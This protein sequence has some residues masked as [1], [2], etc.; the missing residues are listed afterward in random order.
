MRAEPE[1]ATSD[2][3]LQAGHLA[4]WGI[5]RSRAMLIAAALLGAAAMLIAEGRLG[6]LDLHDVVRYSQADLDLDNIVRDVAGWVGVALA[7]SGILYLICIWGA[8][9]FRVSIGRLMVVMA[10][11][12][13]LLQVVLTLRQREQARRTP[14]PLAAPSTARR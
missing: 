5:T 11:L 13:V 6:L 1:G 8:D 7:V 9:R 12:A 14:R 3:P 4:P 2:S 10:M